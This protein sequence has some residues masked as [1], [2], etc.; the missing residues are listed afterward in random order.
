[1]KGCY[2]GPDLA[3]GLTIFKDK[4]RATEDFYRASVLTLEQLNK[5]GI[6]I[7]KSELDVYL[8]D[9]F[10]NIIT[11]DAQWF[12]FKTKKTGNLVESI[13]KQLGIGGRYSVGRPGDKKV[14]KTSLTAQDS[15]QRIKD[16]YL[17]ENAQLKGL[18]IGEMVIVKNILDGRNFQD[19]NL[20]TEAFK[21]IKQIREEGVVEL[22]RLREK[23]EK[24]QEAKNKLLAT[25]F[26]RLTIKQQKLQRLAGQMNTTGE[27]DL[28][29]LIE[30]ATEAGIKVQGEDIH[31]VAN[32]ILIKLNR[33]ASPPF[34]QTALRKLTF[35]ASRYVV[36][37]FHDSNSAI[38]R[39]SRRGSDSTVGGIGKTMLYDSMKDSEQDIIGL[40]EEYVNQLGALVANTYGIKIP[41]YSKKTRGKLMEAEFL[42]ATFTEFAIKSGRTF[43]TPYSDASN[44][45]IVLSKGDLMQLY[46]N[47]INPDA[48]AGMTRNNLPFYKLN[49]LVNDPINGL[50][51]ED[52]KIAMLMATEFYPSMW[53]KENEVHRR[54]Y[55][56]NMPRIHNY[57]G[58]LSYVGDRIEDVVITAE[59]LVDMSSISEV[60]V[61]SK[62]RK[63]KE[64]PLDL[65]VNLFGNAVFRMINSAK[66][67]GGA[68]TWVS[69][70]KALHSV[71]GQ[72]ELGFS[73]N[74]YHKI[75]NHI[76][77][78][79]GLRKGNEGFPAVL[80]WLKSRFTA[81]TLGGKVK[82][83]LNQVTSISTW[84]I[85]KSFWKGLFKKIPE[86]GTT[87]IS[88]L[89]YDASPALRDRYKG[90]NIIALDAQIESTSYDTKALLEGRSKFNKAS[91]KAMRWAMAGISVGDE[92]GVMW[93]G[94][95][96]FK[97]EFLRLREEGKSIEEAKKQA[98]NNFV[99]KFS[100]TQQSFSQMDRSDI[101]NS[102][103]GSLFT[104]FQTTPLQ[105]GRNTM[106]GVD[107][108][109]RRVRGKESKGSIGYNVAR[110]AVFHSIAGMMYYMITQGVV[111][112]AYGEWDEEEW[113]EL[114]Y[115]AIF[116][117]WATS[118]FILGDIID[119]IKNALE[120]KPYETEILQTAAIQNLEKAT[121][122]TIKAIKLASKEH[123]SY[124][125][126]KL[127]EEMKH[128][129]FILIAATGGIPSV[130]LDSMWD[131][132]D[133]ILESDE[134]TL[135]EMFI[136]LGW[137]EYTV[138]DKSGFRKKKNTTAAPIILKDNKA[139]WEK[140][141]SEG[142]K[143]PK[144]TSPFK[145][146]KK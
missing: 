99:R 9:N 93:A 3:K 30:K 135:R 138:D 140:N 53:E 118:L 28:E 121:K 43:S 117:P 146:K 130:Q 75:K 123:L 29:K 67:V 116:G 106:D 46:A 98:V 133:T 96:Y 144:K 37:V 105:Y 102:P 13:Q 129:I 71:R 103:W 124:K 132:T 26:T 77:G 113:N 143:K 50:T 47:A 23:D 95:A 119:G 88:K 142:F 64:R 6:S 44:N 72:I 18:S 60:L 61:N 49:T 85:E 100:N 86:L 59:T 128:E 48:L 78:V 109:V 31:T 108:I 90:I 16:G 14:G 45:P 80:T 101:Q 21:A 4:Y 5:D 114:M 22:D 62:S 74:Y 94:T 120:D 107:Q 10:L 36:N 89:L 25:D 115:A 27:G 33:I 19:N 127:L 32:N 20:L 24:K 7:T 141:K 2:V 12:R 11:K 83:M 76:D 92:A 38:G 134:V 136:L 69:S 111:A 70:T 122:L 51:K 139:G 8:R 15:I 66:F 42:Q 145:K 131:A 35:G 40:K 97:G 104:M 91:N 79:L 39:M 56:I 110:V 126:E 81:A 54:L 125:D 57:A 55:H 34:S 87:N 41:D 68:E 1:M 82:L 84:A 73:S 112:L 52:K 137:S 65:N 17:L 63:E 58:P